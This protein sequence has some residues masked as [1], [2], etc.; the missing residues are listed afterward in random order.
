DAFSPDAFSPD[1]FSTEAFSSVQQSGLIAVSAF[2]GL[3]SE[4]IVFNTWNHPG[5]F[6]VR[7]SGRNG[8][9]SRA[10]PF[11]FSASYLTGACSG[12]E[13]IFPPASLTPEAGNF[14]TLILADF[15][16]MPGSPSEIATLQTRLA[17]LAARP[18]VAGNILDFGND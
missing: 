5:D 6:Y 18:E 16:R 2:S 1:A 17:T 3:T 14:H 8:T 12:V 9:F 13:P 7:I 10:A 11:Y 4:G 15:D